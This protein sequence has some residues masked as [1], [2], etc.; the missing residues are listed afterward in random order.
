MNHATLKA[1]LPAA[2]MLAAGC[3]ARC[4]GVRQSVSC[5][6]WLVSRDGYFTMDVPAGWEGMS[7]TL[8]TNQIYVNQEDVQISV[9]AGLSE[10]LYRAG[11]GPSGNIQHRHLH[12]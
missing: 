7:I 9:R 4:G 10:R 8:D 11:T 3:K 12:I 6:A 5:H 1:L 2:V